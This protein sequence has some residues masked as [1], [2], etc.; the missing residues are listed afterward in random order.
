MRSAMHV[1]TVMCKCNLHLTIYYHV[2]IAL[3]WRGLCY[4]L[5]SSPRSWWNFL[6]KY[7]KSLHFTPCILEPC[8]HHT[9]YK[10]ARMHLTIYVDDIII[11]C[12]NLAYVL[13]VNI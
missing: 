9:I 4:G 13:E 3:S 5:R 2:I 6:D 12:D 10:G 8:L 11:A 7:I 1:L